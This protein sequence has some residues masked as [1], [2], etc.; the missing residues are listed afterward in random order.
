M[1][2]DEITVLD[3]SLSLKK[4]KTVHQDFLFSEIIKKLSVFYL[5]EDSFE[6]LLKCIIILVSVKLM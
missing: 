2:P 3:L 1:K 6:E 5:A 4:K